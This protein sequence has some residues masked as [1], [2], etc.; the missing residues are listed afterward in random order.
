M[1]ENEEVDPF[2]RLPPLLSLQIDRSNF[3]ERSEDA[4]KRVHLRRLKTNL[5]IRVSHSVSHR[6]ILGGRTRIIRR[7]STGPI[8]SRR[9]N[10]TEE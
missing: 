2:C 8:L 3:T 6:E 5:T 1:S 4:R 10:S 9:L 7:T